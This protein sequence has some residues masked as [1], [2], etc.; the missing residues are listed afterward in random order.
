MAIEVSSIEEAIREVREILRLDGADL[1]LE[2]TGEED[3]E[4]KL[5]LENASCEECVMPRAYLERLTLTKLR[6]VVPQITAIRIRDPREIG[7]A[8]EVAN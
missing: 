7:E 1:L 2:R 3:V 8:D 6:E 4:F 5:V